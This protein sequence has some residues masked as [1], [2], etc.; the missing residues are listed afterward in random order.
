VAESD[1][2]LFISYAAA[3]REWAEWIAWTLKTAGYRI[4]I[5]AW[6]FDFSKTTN[7]AEGEIRAR[8]CSD[9]SRKPIDHRC[10]KDA[11]S[12]ELTV[13]GCPPRIHKLPSIAEIP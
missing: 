13:M 5:Q 3:D 12:P 1:L 6:H 9:H 4:R 2:D 8:G 7:L 11:R 10:W